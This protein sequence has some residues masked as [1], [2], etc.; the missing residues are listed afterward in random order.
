MPVFIAEFLAC[1]ALYDYTPFVPRDIV[2]NLSSTITDT[3]TLNGTITDVD[4]LDGTIT[5]VVT[6]DAPIYG[7]AS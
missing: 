6:L 4:T 7:D 2:V 1:N 3:T 5:D